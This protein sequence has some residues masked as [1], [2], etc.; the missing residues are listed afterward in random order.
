[1]DLQRQR[2]L[3]GLKTGDGCL[4]AGGGALTVGKGAQKTGT[5]LLSERRRAWLAGSGGL[6]TGASRPA[7]RGLAP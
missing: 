7:N 4:S 1:M 6:A 3:D 2:C 5:D